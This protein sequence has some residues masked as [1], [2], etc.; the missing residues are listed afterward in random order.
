M[1]TSSFLSLLFHSPIPLVL[2]KDAYGWTPLRRAAMLGHEGVKD[3][4]EL[5]LANKADVN[6][7]A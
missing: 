6:T 7:K 2:S 5:L 3:V 4:I 1:K